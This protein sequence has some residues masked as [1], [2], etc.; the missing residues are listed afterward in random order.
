[1]GDQR[2]FSAWRFLKNLFGVITLVSLLFAYLSPVL[3]PAT[4]WII[5]FFG[6]MYP[7]ILV[8]AIFFTIIAAYKKSKWAIIIGTFL[9][10]GYNFH[11]RLLAIGSEATPDN[12]E[13]I[14]VMSYNV[15][16][17][18]RYGDNLATSQTNRVKMITQIHQELPEIICFQEFYQ[19]DKPTSF[20]TRDTLLQLFKG[21]SHHEKFMHKTRGHQN[22]GVCIMSK[23]PIIEKGNITFDQNL[24]SSNYCIYTDIVKDKDT[25]RVYNVH[26]QSVKLESNETSS[27]PSTDK[28]GWFSILNKLRQAYPVRAD[29][30]IRIIEHIESSP[31]EVIVCGDF[32]DTPMSYTYSQF[33]S[34]LTDSFLECGSGLG[35]T[36]AGN[37]P[38]GRIDYIFHTEGLAAGNFKIQNETL[39]DHFAISCEVYQKTN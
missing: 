32:N 3:H 1:M 20:S 38:A 11:F 17:F 28:G 7:L 23:Y 33:N 19:Q 31:Y 6:L 4:A 22:F 26:L 2:L 14:K 29:Q 5:P 18:D 12:V 13:M 24:T 35:I 16:L 8:F 34:R 27:L 30:A 10:L 21:F 25:I 36:Y 9:L 15:R 39:S 37:L